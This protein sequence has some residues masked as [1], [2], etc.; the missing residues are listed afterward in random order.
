MKGSRQAMIEWLGRNGFSVQSLSEDLRT[1]AIFQWAKKE[2]EKHG[3]QDGYDFSVVRSALSSLLEDYE[4]RG[5]A[6]AKPHPGSL[7]LLKKL[8]S[9]QIISALVTNS[10]GRP[11]R[12]LLDEFGF[13]PY[14]KTVITRDEVENLKPDP[15]GI[16]TA[17]TKLNLMPEDV[18]YVGDSIIDIEASKSAGIACIALAQGM[19]SHDQLLK[20][21]PNFI[22]QN[23][24]DVE[25]IIYS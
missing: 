8:K 25:G 12:Q 24:E 23:I 5:F 21:K 7:H 10:G 9:D 4:Y 18:V 13:E 19:Y 1:L 3:G 14:L 15:E 20:S 2:C 22:I 6:L 11:V 16:T 17:M